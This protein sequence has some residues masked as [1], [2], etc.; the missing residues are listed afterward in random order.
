M[1]VVVALVTKHM[2][3][4]ANEDNGDTINDYS[5]HNM[6]KVSRITLEYI[7]KVIKR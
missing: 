1:W 5:F 7:L 2:C 6:Y 4:L 3:T